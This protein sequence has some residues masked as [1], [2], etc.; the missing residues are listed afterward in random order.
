MCEAWINARILG[1]IKRSQIYESI[2]HILDHSW[3]CVLNY[4]PWCGAKLP[5]DDHE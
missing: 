3:D 5:D 2:R 1:Y 4:C